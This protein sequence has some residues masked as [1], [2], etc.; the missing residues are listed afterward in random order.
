MIFSLLTCNQAINGRSAWDCLVDHV[1]FSAIFDWPSYFPFPMVIM[2]VATDGAA[3][4]QWCI[5]SILSVLKKMEANLATEARL[6]VA[7]F[8]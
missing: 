4:K 7:V 3:R 1:Y 5:S 2:E 8:G 6:M